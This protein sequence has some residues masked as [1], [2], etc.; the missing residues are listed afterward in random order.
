MLA[1]ALGMVRISVDRADLSAG[2]PRCP[3]RGLIVRACAY[4][5]GMVRISVD[6][7]GLSAGAPRRPH[8]RRL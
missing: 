4:A 2:A 8:Q 3:Q 5:L 6:R 1:P 7:A